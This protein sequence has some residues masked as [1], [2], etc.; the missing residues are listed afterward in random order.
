M[1]NFLLLSDIKKSFFS[2]KFDLPMIVALIDVTIS[3]SLP[4]KYRA[5]VHILLIYLLF[6][7]Q[8]ISIFNI[9]IPYP[10]EEP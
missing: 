8:K 2:D 10:V 1:V 9:N 4:T 3:D 6:Y 5:P 7:Q